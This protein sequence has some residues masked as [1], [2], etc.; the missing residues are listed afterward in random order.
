[1]DEL[2]HITVEVPAGELLYPF[3]YTADDNF[4]ID[5]TKYRVLFP[6]AQLWNGALSDEELVSMRVADLNGR[7][8]VK[9]ASNF[10]PEVTPEWETN[11]HR[12]KRPVDQLVTELARL[13]A[14]NVG[15]DRV[16]EGRRVPLDLA[17]YEYDNPKHGSGVGLALCGVTVY[18]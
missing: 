1:M 9:A 5:G 13:D 7:D 2:K 18:L 15:K 10:R 17:V 3:V 8:Y 6:L 12:G 11:P 14:R 16:F 4:G